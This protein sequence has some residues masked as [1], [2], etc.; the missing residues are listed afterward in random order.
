MALRTP[1]QLS[2]STTNEREEDSAEIDSHA[3]PTSTSAFHRL[4][5]SGVSENLILHLAADYDASASTSTSAS[6]GASTGT[7]EH[8]RPGISG[9]LA[10]GGYEGIKLIAERDKI[11]HI[12]YKEGGGQA[13]YEIGV[14]DDGTLV[15]ITY[16]DM[17]RSL[18]TLELMAAELG[19]TVMVLRTITLANPPPF[20]KAL[21]AY[22]GGES[23]DDPGCDGLDADEFGAHPDIKK[24]RSPKKF[25]KKAKS[26]IVRT[27]DDQHAPR[28]PGTVS[29]SHGTPLM[30]SLSPEA[31]LDPETQTIRRSANDPI[32]YYERARRKCEAKMARRRVSSGFSSHE[33]SGKQRK[34]W[35]AGKGDNI[36]DGYGDS[37][38]DSTD[39]VLGED[40]GLPSSDMGRVSANPCEVSSP[41]SPAL[42]ASPTYGPIV[43]ES[44]RARNMARALQQDNT[45]W[46]NKPALSPEERDLVRQARK[47]R[48]AFKDQQSWRCDKGHH[49]EENASHRKDSSEHSNGRQKELDGDDEGFSVF[50]FDTFSQS[51]SEGD[52][53]TREALAALETAPSYV[54]EA[55]NPFYGKGAPSTTEIDMFAPAKRSKKMPKKRRVR[56]QRAEERRLDLLRG[57]GTGADGMPLFT[58]PES[59]ALGTGLMGSNLG[60]AIS[61]REDD[62]TNAISS[63]VRR[64]I[65]QNDGQPSAGFY[66]GAKQAEERV[67]VDICAI[68]ST[69]P[70]YT[71]KPTS[72]SA[73]HLFSLPL[74]SSQATGLLFD[75]CSAKEPV[76]E[77][78]F[79]P[80]S[81]SNT[82]TMP[83][84]HLSLSFSHC[85]L[86][87]TVLGVVTAS[88][89]D[90]G[91]HA[92]S[93]ARPCNA[94]N[95]ACGV[96]NPKDI[97]QYKIDELDLSD[98][99]LCVE[100]LIVKKMDM[101]E[102][103]LD[104][105]GFIL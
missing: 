59:A 99:R 33:L 102:R 17:D 74:P 104:F 80:P 101:D 79:S 63:V 75:R 84:D 103:Y 105:S 60:Y 47:S 30:D 40:H 87:T 23:E 62:D 41:P 11:G 43:A 51:E 48:K 98:A 78:D 24:K 100:A 25:K 81:P 45:R 22:D 38:V 77:R 3:S 70:T 93:E 65:G 61:D 28:I 32:E 19:A 95:D 89:H 37:D 94:E 5:S 91:E 96:S 71:I 88:S 54:S 73:H 27:L 86:C 46:H 6:F 8:A 49:P 92:S 42:D 64:L 97:K 72:P 4:R 12:E 18:E 85:E 44:W 58:D 14:L 55:F 10:G 56:V 15:G 1:S 50:N 16:Q 9:G 82:I 35:G 83:L 57:D 36:W 39:K 31:V 7:S 69:S 29:D 21:M 68:L 26:S 53:L 76:S 67:G 13:V 90:T 52:P 20:P 2:L 34:A 66:G